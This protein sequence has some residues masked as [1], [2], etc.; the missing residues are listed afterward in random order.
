MV[1]LSG[2]EISL[3]T[4]GNHA[5]SGSSVR[6]HGALLG[7]E[8]GREIFMGS[9]CSCPFFIGG[10][11][12]CHSLTESGSLQVRSANISL[13][14]ASSSGSLSMDPVTGVS[15]GALFPLFSLLC[16]CG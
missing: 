9:S 7:L 3:G 2:R 8:A 16:W 10:L 5:Q 15:I 4:L 14:D 1:R 13:G 11:L 6:V 12:K